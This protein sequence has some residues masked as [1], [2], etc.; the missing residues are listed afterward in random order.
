MKR[1]LA[2]AVIFSVL[3]AVILTSVVNATGEPTGKSYFYDYHNQALACPPPYHTEQTIY[4]TF[5]L[6]TPEDMMVYNGN[7]YILD[8]TTKTVY[9]L[10][11]QYKLSREIVLKDTDDFEFVEPRGLWIDEK[12]DFYIADRMG[13]AIVKM[14]LNGDIIKVYHRP[15]TGLETAAGQYLPLKVVTDPLG[16]IYVLVGNEYRGLVKLNQSGE[17]MEYFGP[18]P[19]E[20][21]AAL[22]VD[23]FWRTYI[24]NERQIDVSRRNLPP[25]YS[26]INIHEGFIYTCVS[27]L[28]SGK[29]T[30][31]K[32]NF[33]GQNVL[34]TKTGFGDRYPN[35]N[36]S[37][38][39]IAVDDEGFIS[40][41]DINTKKIFQYDSDG[42]LLYVFGGSGEQSGT[43]ENPVAIRA[44][45][46]RLFVLDKGLCNI[47]IMAPSEFGSDV[48]N[49]QT[50]ALKGRYN[51]AYD[52]A[53]K[54]NK[55]CMGYELAY[56]VLGKVEYDKGNY[57]KAMEYFKSSYSQSDYSNVFRSARIRFMRNNYHW[58]MT[59]IVVIAI[60]VTIYIVIQRKRYKETPRKKIVLDSSGKLKYLMF[61]MLHPIEGF[62]ELRY[63]KKHSLA[64]G[65]SCYALYFF[66]S[67]LLFL[68][69]GF[70]FQI[71]NINDFNIWFHLST[72]IGV[73]LL[74]VLSNYFSS[75]F[76]TGVASLK[77]LWICIGYAQIPV[78]IGNLILLFL[79]NVLTADE[80]M[81]LQY[82]TFIAS[83]Y[84]Y[85]LMFFAVKGLQMFGFVRAFFSVLIT[86]FGMLIFVFL[87]FLI[88]NLSIQ[89][90]SF[91]ETV[92]RELVYRLN[93]GF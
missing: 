24:L 49:C 18:N 62:E 56:N 70:S 38:N 60:L 44:S 25:E 51:Q 8:S 68:Y 41:I 19:M 93:A 32:I 84:T 7:I 72:T 50:N 61:I 39:A 46:D 10:D 69:T 85:I 26:N 45:G 87:L 22:L 15:K 33:A 14:N 6:V 2:V 66:T 91:I 82:I 73:L 89:F 65:N 42:N 30:I 57:K 28:K 58:A 54:I 90:V 13:Q 76:L 43:F 92:I 3:L 17:F 31:R 74:F 27:V 79:S 78:I 67:V 12:G 36:T 35:A 23:N 55:T 52:Y 29:E 88:F 34:K 1:K 83:T 86:I 71:T 63:N 80:G 4:G 5:G 75:T 59:T 40:A 21:T 81:F 11:K 47:T 77:D 37:F 48:R 9:E 16:Y 20:I 64:I 53:L